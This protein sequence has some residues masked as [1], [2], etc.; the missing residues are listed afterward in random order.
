[1]KFLWTTIDPQQQLPRFH[2][3]VIYDGFRNKVHTALVPLNLLMALALYIWQAFRWDMP[4]AL[5]PYQVPRE[6]EGENECVWRLSDTNGNVLY[7]SDPEHASAWMETL[8]D[9]MELVM[10]CRD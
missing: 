7:T 4:M 2:G 6:R 10:F 1:M 3:V 9:D 5:E 8:G